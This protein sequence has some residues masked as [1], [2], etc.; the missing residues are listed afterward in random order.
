MPNHIVRCEPAPAGTLTHHPVDR[1]VGSPRTQGPD[2]IAP[3]P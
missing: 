3:L 2:L 1:R